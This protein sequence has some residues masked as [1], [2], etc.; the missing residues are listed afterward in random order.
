[1]VPVINLAST[2]L[3]ERANCVDNCYPG[4]VTTMPR[5]TKLELQLE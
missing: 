4:L 3:H 2:W 1:M 5:I